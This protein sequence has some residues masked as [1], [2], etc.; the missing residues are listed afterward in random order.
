MFF[1]LAI[2]EACKYKRLKLPNK[3]K[4]FRVILATKPLFLPTIEFLPFSNVVKDVT[5]VSYHFRSM[6]T[7][8]RQIFTFVKL[9]MLF[10]F[11]CN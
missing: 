8:N 9:S 11:A 6:C 3:R 7:E 2:H 10:V 1:S 4:S 5:G